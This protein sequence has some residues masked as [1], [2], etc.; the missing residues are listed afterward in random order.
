HDLLANFLV[1]NLPLQIPWRLYGHTIDS[2]DDVR[3]L[4]GALGGGCAGMDLFHN[5]AVLHRFGH[6][7]EFFILGKGLN[8]DADPR[9]RD[10]AVLDELLGRIHSHIDRDGK[11]DAA[12]QAADQRIDADDAAFDVAKWPA[13]ITGID[14]RVGLDVVDGRHNPRI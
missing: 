5:H 11:A 13:G 8:A 2:H 4:E 3:W 7:R 14:R 12:I 1:E 9:A 6:F 10:F